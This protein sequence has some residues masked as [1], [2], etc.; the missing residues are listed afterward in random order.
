MEP[1]GRTILIFQPK[2]RLFKSEFGV[3]GLQTKM[4]FVY[5][6]NHNMFPVR[7]Q[8]FCIDRLLLKT[9]K[10]SRYGKM[11]VVV[12]QLH[13]SAPGSVSIV[14]EMRSPEKTG[15]KWWQLRRLVTVA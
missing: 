10:I 5:L 4:I 9:Q 1:S 11:E 13:K 14:L 3:G 2:G 15:G 7:F 6:V 8:V 12:A